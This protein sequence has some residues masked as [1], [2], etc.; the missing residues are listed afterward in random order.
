MQIQEFKIRKSLGEKILM[1]TAY[2]A[3]HAKLL[4]ATDVDLLLVGDSAAMLVHGF[5]STLHAT[6]EMMAVHTAAVVRG[7]RGKNKFVVADMPFLS[8]RKGL[9]YAMESVEALMRAGANAVKI[10][11]VDGHQEIISHIVKSGVP[12][13]GHLGLTPQSVHQLGGYRVQAK[14]E[15]DQK[16]LLSDSQKLQNLGCFSVVLE[17]VP[18]QIAKTVSD[19]IHI[20]TIGIGAGPFTDGQVLVYHDLLG[21]NGQ[22]KPKFLR[23]YLSGGQDQLAAVNQFCKDVKI[24]DFPSALESYNS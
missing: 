15:E 14:S 24:G 8:V 12:V 13:M 7:L 1:V 21:L 16:I 18:T 3:S 6:V 4:A 9:I 22:F 23:Q 17:C 20:P 2:D 19:S 10:E 5:D 11:G